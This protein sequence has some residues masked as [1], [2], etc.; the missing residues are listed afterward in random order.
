M[1]DEKLNKILLTD[2][3]IYFAYT[4]TSLIIALL[5]GNKIATYIFAIFQC[6]C[7]GM[8][9]FFKFIAMIVF[10]SNGDREMGK[11]YLLGIFVVLLIGVP[12]CFGGGNIIK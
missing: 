12:I 1:E 3:K 11:A 8:H 10:F 2:I 9:I 5:I 7:I 6:F 4:I